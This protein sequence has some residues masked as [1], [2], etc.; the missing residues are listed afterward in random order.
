MATYI[1][2][3]GGG[4]K[5]RL[6]IQHDGEEPRFV[7]YEET[8]RFLELGYVDAA[9]SFISMLTRSSI[10]LQDV[11]SVAI[12]LAGASL[13]NEQRTFESVLSEHVRNAKVTVQSDST[14]ALGAAFPEGTGMIVIA[15][16]GSVAVGRNAENELCYVG[17]W[18]RFIGDEGSGH[19]IGLAA[20]RHFARVSDG[21]G[22]G[23]ALFKALEEALGSSVLHDPRTLRTSVARR[24]LKPATFAPLVFDHAEDRVART[25]LRQASGELAELI[26][27]CATQV[28]FT[29]EVRTVG[30]VIANPIMLQFVSELIAANGL[31]ISPLETLAPVRHALELARA[32]A[33]SLQ[34]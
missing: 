25:I 5:T 22:R 13:E 26:T 24:D 15:G 27:S 3:D 19:A 12:G 6:Q 16:T 33:N 11:Q 34:A 29:G 18:G 31:S 23:G 7:E 9:R 14:L 20:L 8:F 21:R 30:S 1:G 32:T 28:G 2:V 4:T 10:D 17:G